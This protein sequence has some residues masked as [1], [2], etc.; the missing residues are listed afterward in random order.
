LISI[1]NDCCGR[2]DSSIIILN[3]SLCLLV[4]LFVCLFVCL[5]VCHDHFMLLISI[6][7]LPIYYSM[8]LSK[9]VALNWF[10]FGMIIVI[11]DCFVCES[12]LIECPNAKY[13][14]QS[15]STYIYDLVD[16]FYSMLPFLNFVETKSDRNT[17]RRDKQHIIN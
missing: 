11:C 12:Q 14:H 3:T 4:C 17:R 8:K 9:L 15:Y 10:S 6:N 13:N 2:V 1:L 5:L 16:H 7:T